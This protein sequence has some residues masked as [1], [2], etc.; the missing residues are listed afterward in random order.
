VYINRWL[1]EN[2]YLSFASE[3]KASI[4]DMDPEKT[5]AFCMDPGR[6][7]LNVKRRFPAGSVLPGK[8]AQ[9]LL[10]ELAQGLGE[11]SSQADGGS[12]E[13]VLRRVF[14]KEELY[15]GPF[16]TSAP[17]LVLL[18]NPGNNLRGATGRD[19]LFDTEGPFTGMHTQDDAFF[20]SDLL[21]SSG[22]EPHILDATRTTAS[23]LG[24]KGADALEGRDLLPGQNR[25]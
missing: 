24:L 13:P 19:S 17:D 22:Q 1:E 15:Q 4:A 10:D 8:A 11:L 12:S 2:G 23:L 21:C 6:I 14:R 7:Y 18:A 25:S 3:K 20:L 5:K 16:L 9:A